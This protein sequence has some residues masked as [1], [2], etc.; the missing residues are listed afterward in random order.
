MPEASTTRGEHP[1]VK[2]LCRRKPSK[3]RAS[4]LSELWAKHRRTENVFLSA[5]QLGV[6][7]PRDQPALPL[8]P[9]D[10][11]DEARGRR[12]RA[13]YWQTQLARCAIDSYA[14]LG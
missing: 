3:R 4:T 10:R 8:R 14:S 7:N 9:H 11:M 6:V 13:A 2:Q 12:R 1:R 5:E